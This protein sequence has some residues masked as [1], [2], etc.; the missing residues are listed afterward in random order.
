MVANSG[1]PDRSALRPLPND[2]YVSKVRL[3]VL[4]SKLNEWIVRA[5]SALTVKIIYLA[6]FISNAAWFTASNPMGL[7]SQCL[8]HMCKF[9]CLYLQVFCSWLCPAATD[10]GLPIP[11][12]LAVA[13]LIPL[14]YPGGS[15]AM[16]YLTFLRFLL[17]RADHVPNPKDLP[18]P[19]ALLCYSR[20]TL[21][22][23]SAPLFL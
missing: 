14:L 6:S 13:M 23:Y 8:S 12:L 21:S 18:P 9:S 3:G 4:H 19:S 5:A 16:T 20:A 1:L 2:K 7:R 15:A 22:F 17:L 11:H 10:V